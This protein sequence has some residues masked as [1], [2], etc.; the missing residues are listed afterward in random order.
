VSV[1][2][3][4]FGMT[5]EVSEDLEWIDELG[6]EYWVYRRIDPTGRTFVLYR[7]HSIPLKDAEKLLADEMRKHSPE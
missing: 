1:R 3:R 4:G 6:G 2:D 5:E 7:E